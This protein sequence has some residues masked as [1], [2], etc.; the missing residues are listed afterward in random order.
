LVV[1]QA[2]VKPHNHLTE[3]EESILRNLA[4]GMNTAEISKLRFTSTNTVRAHVK[5]ILRKLGVNTRLQAITLYRRR[6]LE[7]LAAR[8]TSTAETVAESE[9]D[10]G[11]RDGHAECATQIRKML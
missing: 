4:S 5:S 10:Q 2:S 1:G 11:F 9:W 6:E 8:W 7:A 3:S